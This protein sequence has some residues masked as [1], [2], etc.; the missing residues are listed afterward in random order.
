MPTCS[1]PCGLEAAGWQCPGW[2]HPGGEGQRCL[3]GTLNP[4]FFLCKGPM[5]ATPL[6][7]K[8]PD[9]GT[10]DILPGSGW[11]LLPTCSIPRPL[12]L[13]SQELRGACWASAWAVGGRQ[14]PTHSRPQGSLTSWI[15]CLLK[16]LEGNMAPQL[17]PHLTLYK[18][19]NQGLARI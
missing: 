9:H 18:R 2:P 8:P 13:D 3:C 7:Q 14:D 4:Q 11:P 10:G 19:G 17:K 15:Q 1:S 6:L 16:I 12:H 5:W